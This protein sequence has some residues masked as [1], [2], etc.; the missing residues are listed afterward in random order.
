MEMEVGVGRRGRDEAWNAVVVGE[1]ASS[2]HD[3]ELCRLFVGAV[4]R[5]GMSKRK[6]NLLHR[7]EVW[8]LR[9]KDCGGVV[10]GEMLEPKVWVDEVEDWSSRSYLGDDLGGEDGG[11]EIVSAG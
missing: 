6:G 11:E 2:G 10:V 1:M 9:L 4:Q 7:D 5:R 8:R 3:A